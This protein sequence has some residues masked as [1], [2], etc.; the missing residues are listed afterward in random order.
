MKNQQLPLIYQAYSLL[1]HFLKEN[2]NDDFKFLNDGIKTG[3][4]D[5][6]F[7]YLIRTFSKI[8]LHKIILS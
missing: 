4:S 3:V 8:F 2:G 7:K 1:K 6:Q 5:D